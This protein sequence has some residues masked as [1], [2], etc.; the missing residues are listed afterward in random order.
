MCKSDCQLKRQMNKK[1]IEMTIKKNLAFFSG[2]DE[3]NF[4]SFREIRLM[5]D[6]LF[7]IH[8]DIFLDFTEKS[9]RSRWCLRLFLF[10]LGNMF[11]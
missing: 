7:D 5:N 3:W 6:F 4:D 11:L 9:A 10:R 1:Q 8:C 2:F